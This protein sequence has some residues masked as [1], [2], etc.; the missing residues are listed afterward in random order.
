MQKLKK[1]LKT[2][3]REMVKSPAACV[4]ARVHFKPPLLPEN[5]RYNRIVIQNFSS[6]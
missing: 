3:K 1:V 2:H 5:N 4:F 6:P